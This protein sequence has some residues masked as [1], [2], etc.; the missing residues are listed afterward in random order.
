MT[1]VAARPDPDPVLIPVLGDKFA[2]GW[3]ENKV[4]E[5]ATY[6]PL[7]FVLRSRYR[8]DAHFAAYSVPGIKRRLAAEVE[9]F[10]RLADG[11]TML[12][13][14]A[15]VDGP[16]HKCTDEWWNEQRPKIE[17]LLADH[18]GAFVYRTRGGYRLIYVLADPQVLRS[19]AD[20]DLWE[21]RYEAWLDYLA[22]RYEIVGD[23]GCDDW[24]RLFRLPHTTRDGKMQ[25]LETIGNPDAIGLWSVAVTVELPPPPCTR[26]CIRYTPR[27]DEF[28]IRE[29]I[30]VEYP[31]AKHKASG[32]TMKVH[33]GGACCPWTHEHSAGSNGL[34]DTTILIF[35]SGA[36]E[37]RCLHEHCRGRDAAAFRRYHQ[38][39]W[40][41]FDP[42]RPPQRS[43]SPPIPSEEHP[44]APCVN[45]HAVSSEELGERLRPPVENAPDDPEA[46]AVRA[47]QI[48]A[49]TSESNH[50][51]SEIPDAPTDGIPPPTDDPSDTAGDDSPNA[52]WRGGDKGAAALAFGYVTKYAR[53][54]D[55]PTLRK[56]KGDFYGWIPQFGCYRKLTDDQIVSAI[57]RKLKLSD[58][59][60]ARDVRAALIAV[61]DVL[62]DD[63]EIGGWIGRPTVSAPALELAPVR[64]GLLHLRTGKLY[65]ATPLYFTTS[66][67]GVAYGAE[68]PKP[69]EWLKFLGQLWPDDSESKNYESIEALQ[70]WM[71]YLL[72]PDTSFH[73]ILL[74]VGP[75]RSGKGTIARV[76]TALLGRDSVIAPTL[77][78]LGT[79]FGLAPLIGKIAAIIGDARLGG[80]ADVPQVVE[81]L[82]NLSG[83]DDQSVD[84]KH[85]EA[86]HG[87]LMARFAMFTNE[88]PRFTDASDALPAR[89]IA[90]ELIHSFYGHEDRTLTDKLIGGRGSPGELPGILLW[91]IEGW[92]RLQDRGRFVQPVSSAHL[93]EDLEDLASPVKAWARERCEQGPTRKAACKKAFADFQRWCAEDAHQKHV[94]TATRFGIDLR[95]AVQVKR[96]QAGG[97]GWDYQGIELKPEPEHWRR[98]V[99]PPGDG[100]KPHWTADK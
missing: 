11:V 31:G 12:L 65:D 48:G 32:N 97:G 38:P 84:R 80:R 8:T 42:S 46:E 47:E 40:K 43:G 59:A 99:P 60:T 75:K 49:D 83:E 57:Q 20:A 71:G 77:A 86:W 27:G 61:D 96:V 25:E 6:A 88:P 53:H 89:M 81:R 21:L 79:N 100:D 55:G 45:G 29:L 74:M 95:T 15:D 30:A 34:T 92:K 28:D 63:V 17:R 52:P 67:L 72:T 58:P 98:P 93:I 35:E 39:D 66:S 94:V 54:P 16:N 87:Q 44:N 85:R 26:T 56:W 41:P 69:T 51:D 22:T 37:F 2:R 19:V 64:N 5:P 36:Y 4:G 82:L 13:F 18:P 7:S 33:I 3:P 78:S 62:I 50:A 24:T 70:E 73:K 68:A 76:I 1:A 23:R 9:V 91:A 10:A 14:V 90:L